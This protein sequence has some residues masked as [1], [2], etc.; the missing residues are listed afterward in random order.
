MNRVLSA[1]LSVTSVQGTTFMDTFRNHG[2]D[3]DLVTDFDF[4]A[5]INFGLNAGPIHTKVLL[6][7]R[8]FNIEK[9]VKANMKAPTTK[10]RRVNYSQQH[11]SMKNMLANSLNMNEKLIFGDSFYSKPNLNSLADDS[12]LKEKINSWTRN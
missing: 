12:F 8:R 1:T 7:D 11:R 10:A 6:S 4:M 2:V 9:K 5:P 3:R